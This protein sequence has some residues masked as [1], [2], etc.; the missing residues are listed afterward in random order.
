MLLYIGLV[1]VPRTNF[2]SYIF[3][4]QAH[5]IFIFQ[6]LFAVFV[7]INCHWLGHD[8]SVQSILE[9]QCFFKKEV[10]G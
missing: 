7:Y 1:D 3:Y 8:I 4:S 10:M 6:F 5:L 9:I 2:G